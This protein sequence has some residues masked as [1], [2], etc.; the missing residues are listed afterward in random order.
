MNV[1]L[2]NCNRAYIPPASRFV[3]LHLDCGICESNPKNGQNEDVG[4]EDWFDLL[5]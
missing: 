2:D 3:N 1:H 4:Y 5:T